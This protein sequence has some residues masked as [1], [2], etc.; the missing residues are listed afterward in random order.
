MPHQCLNKTIPKAG[1]AMVRKMALYGVFRQKLR[2]AALMSTN[3]L[4]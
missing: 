2:C 3:Q 4:Q 1:P